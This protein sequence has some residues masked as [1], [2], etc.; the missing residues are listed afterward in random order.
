MNELEKENFVWNSGE[1]PTSRNY[2]EQSQ[3]GVILIIEGRRMYWDDIEDFKEYHENKKI[4]RYSR[5]E[6]NKNYY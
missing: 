1:K 6:T 3:D 4:E 5:K 2:F